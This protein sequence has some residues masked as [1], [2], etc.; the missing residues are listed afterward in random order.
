MRHAAPTAARSTEPHPE[1]AR[2]A[3]AA[4]FCR[5]ALKCPR[6]H[7]AV[8]APRLSFQAANCP[9]P[10]TAAWGHNSPII[11]PY[12]LSWVHAPRRRVPRARGGDLGIDS[13]TEATDGSILVIGN[14]HMDTT[15]AKRTDRGLRIVTSDD[16]T[17]ADLSALQRFWTEAQYLTLTNHSHRSAP[18][19]GSGDALLRRGRQ[20]AVRDGDQP[21][22][23][24]RRFGGRH[25]HPPLRAGGFVAGIRRGAH[26]S[27]RLHPRGGRAGVAD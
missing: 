10:R 9:S 12:V 17:V 1:S 27:P 8:S 26:P 21:D 6:H 4:S 25:H 5:S 7:L 11:I 16:C 22:R 2:F 13:L 23:A 3:P 18:K 20:A 19:G 24:W 14:G 15:V